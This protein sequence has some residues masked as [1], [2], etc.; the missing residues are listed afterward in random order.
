MLVSLLDAPPEVLQKI[1]LF[2]GRDTPLGPPGE[3]YCLLLTCRTLHCFLTLNSSKLYARIFAQK[4]DIKVPANRLGN[5]L[6]DHAN[7]E[8]RRRF[9][10]LQCFRRGRVDDE[11]LPQAFWIAYFMMLENEGL[12]SMQLRWAGLPTLV[13]RFLQRHLHEGS[14]QNNGWPVENE[15]NSLAI[16]LLWLLSSQG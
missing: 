16:A 7:V 8:L 1:V 9:T 2:A 14:V 10:A 13:N 12:N 3:L 11:F 15:T 6:Q 4:F 5:A